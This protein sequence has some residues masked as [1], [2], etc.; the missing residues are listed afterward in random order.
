MVKKVIAHIG[1]LLL[2]FSCSGEENYM[3]KKDM[4][5]KAK[6]WEKKEWIKSGWKEAQFEDAQKKDPRF[7]MLLAASIGEG[8]TCK[9]YND[10]IGCIGVHNVL[11]RKVEFTLLEFDSEINAISLTKRIRGYHKFNWVFDE[12]RGEPVLEDFVKVAFGA[13]M[14]GKKVKEK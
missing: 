1:I 9:N 14:V 10:P 4:W 7:E 2:F 11:V 12:V 8:P 13:K 3:G 5:L 6:A